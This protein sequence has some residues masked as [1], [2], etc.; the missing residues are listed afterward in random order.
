MFCST[1]SKSI[2]SSCVHE[3]LLNSVRALTKEVLNKWVMF[4][5]MQLEKSCTFIILEAS[6]K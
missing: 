3:V 2:S 6:R 4:L 5:N 1:K